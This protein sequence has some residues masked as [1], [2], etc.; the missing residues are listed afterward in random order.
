[1]FLFSC[2]E[3]TSK[4]STTKPTN[5][6]NSKSKFKKPN[7]QAPPEREIIDLTEDPM[8]FE[9]VDKINA[10]IPILEIIAN[11]KWTQQDY[12]GLAKFELLDTIRFEKIS[13]KNLDLKF[14]TN[15]KSLKAISVKKSESSL[16]KALNL[17]ITL[18][19]L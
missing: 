4:T 3:E 14:L 9:A 13:V 5:T 7:N 1:M 18:T 16:V 10:E 12:E 17:K 19:E 11:D 8:T 2:S 6:Q 15:I